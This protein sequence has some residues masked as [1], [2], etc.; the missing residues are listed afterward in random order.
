MET[1]SSIEE[2]ETLYGNPVSNSLAKVVHQI[3]P[4]YKQWIEVS[5]FLVL[6]SVGPD[7]CDASPRGDQGNVATVED[8]KTLWIP[9][10]AGNNR[11]DSLKNIINDGRVS[12]LFMVPGCNNVVRVIGTAVLSID[13]ATKS[14]FVKNNKTPKTV[15]VVTVEQA[16]FQ[17]AKALMRSELWASED[18]SHHVPTAGQFLKEIDG[19][20]KAKSY[21]ANYKDHAKGKMW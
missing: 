1:V 18:A 9:D 19:E 4:L 12:L 3:T 7:G 16:Y 6:S 11:L 5:R 21:D 10:W 20:F 8:S 2:L 13:S 17:C 15:I 14:T